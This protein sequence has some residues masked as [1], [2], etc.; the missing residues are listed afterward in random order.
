MGEDT[1]RSFTVSS[2]SL[3]A[4]TSYEIKF[5]EIVKPQTEGFFFAFAP[6]AKETTKYIFGMNSEERGVKGVNIW[7]GVYNASTSM[8]S[9]WDINFYPIELDLTKY[10]AF[11]KD[12]K[13]EDAPYWISTNTKNNDEIEPIIYQTGK[14]AVDVILT[15]NGK[16]TLKDINI[17]EKG[18]LQ[19]W[20]YYYYNDESKIDNN[21]LANIKLEG[22]NVID[23]KQWAGIQ[24][25]RDITFIGDGSLTVTGPNA[26]V[27][28]DVTNRWGTKDNVYK[29]IYEPSVL[30]INDGVKITAIGTIG[31]AI[32]VNK[33]HYQEYGSEEKYEA[34]VPNRLVLKGGSLEATGAEG[35]PAISLSGK[36]LIEPAASV[37]A[38]A[39]K[40]GAFC[41]YDANTGEEAKIED[42]VADKTKFN[43]TIADGVRTIKKK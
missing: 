23:T 2:D 1:D 6:G 31:Q 10:T 24:A 18:Y 41:I 36:M 22:T 40:N 19:T 39:G 9:I 13:K 34:N 17:G 8:S 20:G 27:I 25:A 35:A 30:T 43:D 42:L 37:I 5:A 29:D 26:I 7:E 38:N 28:Y 14:D 33:A 3:I 16:V 12:V 21:Y 11:L 15:I 4:T 32:T